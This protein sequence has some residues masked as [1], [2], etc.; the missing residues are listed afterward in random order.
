MNTQLPSVLITG[1]SSGI[2]AVYADRFARRGHNLVLVARDRARLEALAGRL[3]AEAGVAVDVLPADLAVADDL[4]RVEHRLRDDDRIGIL[5]NNAG[6]AAP[7]TFADA[8]ID[9]VDRLI[10]VNV[11]AV[12]RL[13]AA[14]VP[15]QFGLPAPQLVYLPE[16]PFAV[17][18]FLGDVR[19]CLA[20]QKCVLVAISEGLRTA[21]GVF[22][23]DLEDSAATDAFGHRQ[24]SGAGTG[25][26]GQ[27]LRRGPVAGPVPPVRPV[28][29][30]CRR[31]GAAARA[32][33]AARRASRCR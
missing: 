7:G 8:A 17:E 19:A 14:A 18:R 4:A 26:H 30:A 28:P 32:P 16:V 29:R 31:R 10:R 22:V 1:A 23:C 11:T 6:I 21:E 24:L 15:R 20:E 5:V 12:T 9:S 2:G 25:D 3:R 33:P 13:A 27:G